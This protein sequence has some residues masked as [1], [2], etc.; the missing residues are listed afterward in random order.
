[1]GPASLSRGRV[2]YNEAIA[3]TNAEQ[4]LAW[5][6]KLRY[7]ISSEMLAV[8]SITA[9]VSFSARANAEIGMG[10]A[11]N[12]QGNL[13]PL[14]GG[15]AYEENPTISYL[16]VQGA[17]HMRQLLSPLPLHL[18]VLLLNASTDLSDVMTLLVRR[19][20]GIPNHDFVVTSKTAQDDRFAKVV[21]LVSELSREGAIHIVQSNEK[22]ET[23]YLWLHDYAPSQCG[24]V[25]ELLEILGLREVATEGEP[26]FLA[27]SS[28]L[29]TPTDT[30]I[31]ILTRSVYDLGRMASAGV[32]VPDEDRAAGLTVEYP[33]LGLAGEWIEI[34]R[35]KNRPRTAVA[36]T[37]YRGWWYY[38]DGTDGKSKFFLLILQSLISVGLA[39]RV[40]AS[41]AAPVLTVP[42]SR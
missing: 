36:A 9:N 42:V 17:K 3:Q 33:K 12:Y 8:S 2:A 10:P 4:S 37:K 30:S 34:R 7:G 41:P 23:F 31:S 32:D 21:T 1:M 38:I 29:Q 22:E 6:V 16:P 15:V 18:L 24:Q 26:I 28:A 40:E 39:E 27:L 5:I 19:I 11:E 35:A 14:S 13:V 20:N 25:M